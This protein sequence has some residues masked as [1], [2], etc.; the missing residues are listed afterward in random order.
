M[1]ADRKSAV[2][3]VRSGELC[4]NG[5]SVKFVVL[6]FLPSL[7]LGMLNS[8]IFIAKVE[9]IYLLIVMELANLK[10]ELTS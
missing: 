10:S 1:D 2:L 3:H 9:G 4:E 7:L 8:N 6:H 5:V